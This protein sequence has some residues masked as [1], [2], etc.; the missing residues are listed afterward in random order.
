[1]KL[2]QL[3]DEIK[4]VPSSLKFFKIPIN[5]TEDDD[6][7][8]YTV[9][10][11]DAELVTYQQLQSDLNTYSNDERVIICKGNSEEDANPKV[12]F[13]LCLPKSLNSVPDEDLPGSLDIE[14]LVVNYQG[15]VYMSAALIDT[16][17]SLAKIGDLNEMI[18]L[19]EYWDS[20][21]ISSQQA[22]QYLKGLKGKNI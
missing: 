20:S 22:L 21:A 10:V 2:L 16:N 7:V 13:I 8:D 6:R 14:L 19:S 5:V 9:D 17:L 3:I 18:T 11:D 1:M 4:V 15:S 12:R